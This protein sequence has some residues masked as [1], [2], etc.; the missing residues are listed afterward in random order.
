MAQITWRNV[1]SP[2]FSGALEGIRSFSNLLGGATDG[3]SRAL[4]GFQA[5]DQQQAGNEVLQRALQINDPA[6]Y[7]RAMQD[8]SI[9]GGMDVSRLSPDTLAA[10]GSRQGDLVRQASQQLTTA[11]GQYDF[12]RQQ[13]TDARAAGADRALRNL[14]TAALS[15]DPRAIA[16]AYQAAEASGLR[17]DQ[18]V[19]ATKGAQGVQG[20]TLSNQGR[21]TS[22]MSS[23]YQLGKTMSDDAAKAMAQ[24][25]MINARQGA[26]SERGV[27]ENLA[28]GFDALPAAVQRI[29]GSSLGLGMGGGAAPQ[30]SGGFTPSAPGTAGTR[31]GSSYD[32]TYKFTPTE[33]PITE[34]PIGDV[35]T[36]QAGMIADPNL[37]NSPVGRYQI[38]KATLEQ[39]GPKVLG[40]NWK[41]QPMSPENQERL[42]E[43]LYNDRKGGDLTKTW[44]ALNNS[45]ASAYKDVPWSE[46]RKEIAGGEVSATDNGVE[47]RPAGENTGF[48]DIASRSVQNRASQEAVN[49]ILNNFDTAILDKRSTGDLLKAARDKGGTFEGADPAWVSLQMERAQSIGRDLGVEVPPA[50]ALQ[51]MAQSVGS[52]RTSWAGRAWDAL[53]SSIG[54]GP[55]DNDPNTGVGINADRVR[56]IIQNEYANGR[57]EERVASANYRANLASQIQTAQKAASDASA[58]LAQAMSVAPNNPR[59]AATIPRLRQRV[60]MAQARQ[61]ALTNQLSGSVNELAAQRAVQEAPKKTGTV[62]QSASRSQPAVDYNSL[63]LVP[64]INPTP[65]DL[66]WID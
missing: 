20:S 53:G 55:R 65:S 13:D 62:A 5:A 61:D 7:Q 34:M 28:A 21:Q 19:D 27:Q 47:L 36:H 22:N 40:E 24:D 59:V 58:E 39:Y 60:A 31:Q 6:A 63:N 45:K 15:G 17:A 51:A 64:G 23:Q 30:S 2:N 46:A 43:A 32:A 25:Y 4:G 49:S 16:A 52:G 9:I 12:T 11:K 48:A 41:D 10:L 50:V 3:L 66:R 37:K 44:A 54:G 14:N 56:Q 18:L 57:S 42:A 26:V 29:I 38:N 33:R 8:G 35:L 1:D